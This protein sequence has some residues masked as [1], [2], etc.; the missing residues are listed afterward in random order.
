MQMSLLDVLARKE[1][2]LQQVAANSGSWMD[3]AMA[4]AARLAEQHHGEIVTGEGVRALVEPIAGSPHHHNAWGALTAQLGRKGFLIQTGAW[5]PMRGAKS[6]GRRT[7][8]YRW[9]VPGTLEAA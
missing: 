6:N 5:V 7:P 1:A 3:D 2:A 8:I 4:A 9:S